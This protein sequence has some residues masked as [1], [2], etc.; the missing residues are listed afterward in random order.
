MTDCSDEILTGLTERHLAFVDGVIRLHTDTVSPFAALCAAAISDGIAI[1]VVSS[2]RSFSRQAQIWQAKFNGTKPVFDLSGNVININ[3]LDGMAKLD[4]ILLYSALP[5]A[6]R[7]HWGTDV[8]VYDAA[9]VTPD[10]VPQLLPEEY[11]PQGPFNRL[12][13]WL[14]ENAQRFGFFLPYQHYQGGVAAEPWHL[15][16]QPVA[17]QLQTHQT[18]AMLKHCLLQHPIAGQNLVLDNLE[19]IFN[20]YISNICRS[21]I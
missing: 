12:A 21:E 20:R 7:H 3:Q 13:L 17:E 6:S 9:A 4:A 2:F 16:F 15:S 8:D 10:Y 14:T 5:G 19:Q 1:K 18:P 11:G